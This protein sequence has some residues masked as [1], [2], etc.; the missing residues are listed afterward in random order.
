MSNGLFFRVFR[1][2]GL[3]AMV[4][5][6]FCLISLIAVLVVATPFMAD[7]NK[8]FLWFGFPLSFVLTFWWWRKN[9][10]FIKRAI[11]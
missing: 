6:G 7:F 5:G 1:L 3:F 10:N 9:L 11:S 4:W 2:I 8:V